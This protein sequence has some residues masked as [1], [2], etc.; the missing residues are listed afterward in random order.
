MSDAVGLDFRNA[1]TLWCSVLV[2]TLVRCGVAQAVISPGSRSTPLTV[3]LARHPGIRTT[4]VLDERSAA[5]FALGIARASGRTVVLVCTSGSA[6]A[7]YFPAVIEAQEAGVPLLVVTADRP[8]ELRACASGQTI[9]Q[10]KLFGDHVN[11][12]HEL[13]VPEPTLPLLAYLRQTVAEACRR[14]RQPQAGPVHLNAP[15]R[16]PLAPVGDAR[17]AGLRTAIPA[18]FFAHL[19]HVTPP[20][21]G[22][23]RPWPEAVGERGIIVAGA[24]PIYDA[25]GSVAAVAALARRLGWPILADG[26][27]PL[28][29]AAA[30]DVT[31]I[32]RYDTLLR[33]APTAAALRP[34]QV[35]ALGGWPTSKVLRQWLGEVA[36]DTVMLSGRSDNRDALHGRTR[37]FAGTVGD[38]AIAPA[39]APTGDYAQAWRRADAAVEQALQEF[40]RPAGGLFEGDVTRALAA[41]V[42]DGALVSVASSMPIR[43]VEYF[44]PAN[45]RRCRLHAN[46]GANGIDGT[47]STA[48]GLVAGG[49]DGVLLCGDLAFL[50]DSNGLLLHRSLPSALTVVLVNND[51]GGIFGHLP[52]A[53]FDP[54]FEEYFATPQSVDFAALCRA[55]GVAHTAVRD[56]AH[57]R[58]LVAQRSPRGIRVLEVRTDRK[59]D[60]ATRKQMFAAAAAALDGAAG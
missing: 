18:D 50:H 57:L 16:D 40:P 56:L 23:L 17:T 10:R 33:H 19:T 34:R 22:A 31:V 47:L 38:L 12:F 7:N 46:R 5:F 36:A 15:F 25:E 26:V 4:A 53:D 35:L 60:A 45:A 37:H 32:T 59:R 24:D 43:D 6:G 27:S 3:A 41:A 42:P 14:T 8:P 9:D 58:E 29:H 2:E 1:N 20:T 54:P 21:T 55:H 44:W 49:G 28:R 11:F 48:G 52:I 39:A 51:G 13:A 30:D